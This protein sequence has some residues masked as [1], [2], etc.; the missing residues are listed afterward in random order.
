MAPRSAPAAAAPIKWRTPEDARSDAGLIGPNAV[1]QLLPL[2]ERVG[3]QERVAHMMAEV[4]LFT[5]PDGSAMIPEG[6]AARLHRQ[7][8]VEEPQLA[9]RLAAEAGRRTADYILAHRIPK[10]VQAVLRCLPASLAAQALSQSIARHSWTFAGSGRFRAFSPWRFEIDDN[11]LVRGESCSH[12]LCDWHSAVFARLYEVLVAPDVQCR[13]TS[14]GA[15][16][17]GACMFSLSRSG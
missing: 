15:Q 16:T 12:P 5:I 11:P 4:G 10:P 13:E 2:I 6:D 7:L 14:C 17:G 1:L 9:P 3:G 8:R